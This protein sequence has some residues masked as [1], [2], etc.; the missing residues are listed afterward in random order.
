MPDRQQ[1]RLRQPGAQHDLR[2]RDAHGV[3]QTRLQL[4]DVGERAAPGAALGTSV[5]V[6][7][8]RR[9]DRQFPDHRQPRGRAHRLHAVQRR[10]SGGSPAARRRRLHRRRAVQHHAH[11]VDPAA[12]QLPHLREEPRRSGRELAGR[13]R[14]RHQPA[15]RR[16]PGPGRHQHGAHAHGQLRDSLGGARDHRPQP[17]PPHRDALLDP[18][19]AAR[20]LHDSRNRRAVL[21]HVS[22]RSRATGRGQRRLHLGAG[23]ALARA[24]ARGGGCCAR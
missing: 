6:G 23:G 21:R 12:E 10:R 18:G 14:Q 22:E 17:V 5:D 3:G 24:S 7:Y 15:T 9:W 2:S 13:G 8:F 20:R 1:P 19:E 16:R 4:G 11:G